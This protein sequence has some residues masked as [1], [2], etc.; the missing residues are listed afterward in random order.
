MTKQYVVWGYSRAYRKWLCNRFNSLGEAQQ[1]HAKRVAES[2][3]VKAPCLVDESYDPNSN[4]V[5]VKIGAVL[6]ALFSIAV[7]WYFG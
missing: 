6:F 7:Y 1:Y 4:A 3:K 2:G 5:L